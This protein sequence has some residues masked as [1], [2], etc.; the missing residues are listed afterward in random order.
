MNARNLRSV[1]VPALLS[2]ALASPVFA[3]AWNLAP[4]EYHARF[5]GSWFSSDY[6]RDENGDK[7]LLA[8]GG[9]WEERGLT[10]TVEMGWKKNLNVLIGLP[11]HSVTRRFGSAG[12]ERALP[13]AT[14]L[15]D[16]LFGLRYAL[17]HGSRAAALQ[18]EWKAPLSY[19][20]RRVFATTQDASFALTAND[21]NIE[22]QVA[23]PGL[24]DGQNDVTSTLQIGTSIP[25]G[26]LQIAGGYRY[27]FDAPGDQMVADADLGLWVRSNVMLAGRY[28]GQIALEDGERATEDPDRHLAGPMLVVRIDDR[29]DVIAGS[30]HTVAATNA[31]HTDQVFFGVAFRQNKLNR[32][33]GFLGTAASP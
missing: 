2:L 31:L 15:S 26:F 19:E 23:R 32:R 22:R 1:V 25:R 18:V 7:R 8:L 28:Q 21:A 6:Y 33:Q 30:L 17:V 13:T 9:L 10:A 29:M 11:L 4:G 20:R 27:R 3:G 12:A 16:A 14:G 24:G 5:D